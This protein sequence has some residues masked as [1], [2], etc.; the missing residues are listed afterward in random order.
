[1]E[2]HPMTPRVSYGTFDFGLTAEQEERAARLH[3]DSIICDLLYQGPYSP[4]A[5]TREMIDD[6]DAQGSDDLWQAFRYIADRITSGTL[7]GFRELV[8]QSGIINNMGGCLLKDKESLRDYGDFL[9]RQL[10]TFPWIRRARTAGDIRA[11]KRDG[12][13]VVWG[14]CQITQLRPGD[15]DVIDLAHDMGVLHIA[16]C[17]Y[18]VMTYIGTGCTER[19]DAGLSRFGL[20]FVRRCNEVG[21]IVDTAHS[22]RQTTLDACAASAAPVIASHTSAAALFPHDRAKSD[23]EIRAIAASGGVIG[24][25]VVPF[26]LAPPGD[27]GASIELVLDHMDYVAELVGWQHVA[28][29]TDWPM[30]LPHHV[31]HRA[32]SGKLEEFGFREEHA[33][34]VTQTLAGF[35]DY[36]DMVNIT[37]GLVS[38]GYG[39][40]QIRGILGENFLRVFEAVNG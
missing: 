20:E 18:N 37:R 33:I 1:M 36:R 5:W 31:Q 19:Y 39:D 29:G 27:T 38:R 7:P 28:I 21:V 40:E 11:A 4:D 12:G 13:Q 26:F 10:E 2:D 34:D 14:I 35:R 8:G 32:F 3:R 30:A 15:L 23:E 9:D 16:D 25:Y 22:G 24:V 6:I 17:A